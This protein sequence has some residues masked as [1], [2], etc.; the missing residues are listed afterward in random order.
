MRKIFDFEFMLKVAS[1]NLRDFLAVYNNWV[2]PQVNA[3]KHQ[4]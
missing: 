2:V 1:Y 4:L 3:A